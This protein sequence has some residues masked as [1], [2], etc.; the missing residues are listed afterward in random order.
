M[1][2][3]KT[4]LLVKINF[5]LGAAEG[6]DVGTTP[7]GTRLIVPVLGGTFTGADLQGTVLT[8]GGDWALQRADGVTVLDVRVTL[9]THDHHRIAMT[10]RGLDIS[11]PEGRQRVRQGETVDPSEYYFRTTPYFETGAEQ[12]GWLNRTVAV[13]VGRP[14]PTGVAYEV[15]ALR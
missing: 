4:E 6:Q 10:A 14:T 5:T 9:R 2:H 11:A 12:Y 1:A 13:G 15:Y 7:S 3:V 8:E